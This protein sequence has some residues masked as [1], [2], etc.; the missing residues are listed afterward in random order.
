MFRIKSAVLFIAISFIFSNILFA[1]DVTGTWQAVQYSFAGTEKTPAE[2]KEIVLTLDKNGHGKS[3]V[4]FRSLKGTY[5]FDG[6]T[7][8]LKTKFATIEY[9]LVDGK[10][11]IDNP[12]TKATYQKQ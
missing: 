12:V 5:T 3:K 9:M 2:L 1:A 8:F 11:K 4:G 10:L 6:K 7:V